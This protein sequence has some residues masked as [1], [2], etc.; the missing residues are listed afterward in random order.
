MGASTGVAPICNVT[1][2][3]ETFETN[4]VYVPSIPPATNA[5]LLSIVNTIRQAIIVMNSGPS[6]AGFGGGGGGGGAQPGPGGPGG[7]F[8][9]VKKSD[10]VVIKQ[11]V[12]PVKVYDPNDP[13]KKTYVTVNQ[14]TGLTLQNPITKQKW[15]WNQSNTLPNS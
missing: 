13:S 1:P 11:I 6:G 9:E 8:A 7:G 15:S 5:S 14:V 3:P 4:K 2:P 10:F 12:T